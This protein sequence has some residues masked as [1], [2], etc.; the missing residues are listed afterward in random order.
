MEGIRS[1]ALARFD[2]QI[3]V[4]PSPLH[5]EVTTIA[6]S[7]ATADPSPSPRQLSWMDVQLQIVDTVTLNDIERLAGTNP[8]LLLVRVQYDPPA[9]AHRF[10]ISQPDLSR[11]A[12][13]LKIDE[14]GLGLVSNDT[15][16]FHC[17]AKDEPDVAG[18]DLATNYLYCGVYKLLWSYNP[19]TASTKAIAFTF[20]MSSP[21]RAMRAI[22]GFEEFKTSLQD[23]A[24]LLFDHPLLLPLAGG[25]QVVGFMEKTIRAQFVKCKDADTQSG[26]HPWNKARGD[27]GAAV[28]ELADIAWLMTALV[29]E[30]EMI[31]R[32]LRQWK[33]AVETFAA[34]QDEYE[35]RDQGQT[36]IR[37]A[38][39]RRSI[40]NALGLTGS[41]LGVLELDFN[42]VKERAKNQSSAVRIDTFVPILQKGLS[43]I[44]DPG[45][46]NDGQRRHPRQHP[47][48]QILSPRRRFDE[49]RG[50]HDHGIPPGHLL[51][52]LVCRSLLELGGWRTG[53]T[54][55]LLDILGFHTA[56]HRGGVYPLGDAYAK[57][58][59]GQYSPRGVE[60]V[61]ADGSIGAVAC[62][63]WW[64]GDKI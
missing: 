55:Q 11:L 1:F 25:A 48:S 4:E 50:C 13:I 45:H 34:I 59:V 39:Q 12:R 22:K 53:D 26:V 19:A 21:G 64:G 16:G 28:R 32:R 7:A 10:H 31:V 29:V 51:S 6:R 17:F 56:S 23:Q 18:G 62:G 61:S 27:L 15:T 54:R 2:D 8:F 20:T 44:L 49:G 41:K 24:P 58:G 30:V 38:E 37:S 9:P 60:A 40:S 36:G 5:Y 47:A 14:C 35:R 57:R 43:N 42:C 46:V 3:F 63:K 33:L 52:C